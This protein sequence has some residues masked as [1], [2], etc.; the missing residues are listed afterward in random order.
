[1]LTEALTQIN[2]FNSLK[3]SK[4]QS[5]HETI[6]FSISVCTSPI[7]L[8]INFSDIVLSVNLS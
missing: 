4:L 5:S 6:L 3:K 7:E 8:I 1:M 2:G